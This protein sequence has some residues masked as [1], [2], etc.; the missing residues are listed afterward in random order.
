MRTLEESRAF[1][2]RDRFATEVCGIVIEAVTQEGAKCSMPLTPLHHNAGGV[3]QGGAIYT[4]CDTAFA[5]AANAGGVLTVSRD[6]QVH[7]LR[8][9]TGSR[10]FADARLVS[11]GRTACLYLVEVTDETG[12]LVA[13][14]TVTGFRKSDVKNA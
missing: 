6:A 4:L 13:Y 5:V 9:G 12:A 10:L 1:F 8:P 14:C 3:A 7:Y 11:D 2:A